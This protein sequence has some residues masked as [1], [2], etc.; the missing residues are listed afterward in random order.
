LGQHGWTVDPRLL[1]SARNLGEAEAIQR[2]AVR[3]E[4]VTWCHQG[5]SWVDQDAIGWFYLAAFVF[6]VLPYLAWRIATWSR[7]LGILP[8]ASLD[9]ASRLRT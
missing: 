1:A 3:G 7:S 5:Y 6:V 9:A 2:H 8:R 4:K